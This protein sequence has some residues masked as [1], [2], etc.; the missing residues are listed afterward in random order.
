LSFRG[1]FHINIPVC[2]YKNLKGKQHVGSYILCKVILELI[3]AHK[4]LDGLPKEN[5][6]QTKRGKIQDQGTTSSAKQR[7]LV[8]AASIWTLS[9]SKKQTFYEP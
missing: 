7:N 5:F 4:V 9:K 8:V 6:T 3:V 1:A 2:P